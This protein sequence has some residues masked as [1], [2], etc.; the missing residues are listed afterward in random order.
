M[1][2]GLSEQTHRACMGSGL[3]LPNTLPFLMFDYMNL[4][5]FCGKKKK[6]NLEIQIYIS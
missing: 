3:R 6:I 1:I 4:L 2:F 5:D